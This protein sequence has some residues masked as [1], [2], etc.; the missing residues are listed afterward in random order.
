MDYPCCS[1]CLFVCL[2]ALLVWNLWGWCYRCS[3]CNIYVS[4][5]ILCICDISVL[6]NCKT[7]IHVN[8]YFTVGGEFKLWLCMRK[9]G[10]SQ[11]FP[12]W[13][14]HSAHLKVGTLCYFMLISDL[15]NGDKIT[16][17]WDYAVLF[18]VCSSF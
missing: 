4:V 7:F 2:F 12:F 11:K 10:I 8:S 18:F 9:L 5:T 16:S 6:C 3:V 17:V 13:I 1:L 15:P 14:N